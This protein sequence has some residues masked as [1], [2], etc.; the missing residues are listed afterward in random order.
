MPLKGEKRPYRPT[1]RDFADIYVAHGV[2]GA[3]AHFRAHWRTVVRWIDEGGIDLRRR[4]IEH[5]VLNGR[6]PTMTKVWHRKRMKES[7]E[8][9]V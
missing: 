7:Y 4:R 3:K 1:P 2:N 8:E 5:L 6:A 9:R